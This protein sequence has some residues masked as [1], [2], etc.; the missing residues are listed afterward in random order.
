MDN[1]QNKTLLPTRWY[2]YALAFIAGIFLINIL[3]HFMHGIVGKNFPT[4]FANPP[5]KGLSSPILNVVW[6]IINFLIG[7]SILYF[8]K[9]NRRKNRVL[10]ALFFGIVFMSF[11]LAHYFGSLA[12]S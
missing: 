7:F 11:Y 10:I 8:M 3:P 2:H 12:A 4:P 9:I 6:A 5:G 1:T